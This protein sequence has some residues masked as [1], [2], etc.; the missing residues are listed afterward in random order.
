MSWSNDDDDDLVVWW[1]RFLVVEDCPSTVGTRGWYRGHWDREEPGKVILAVR[2]ANRNFGNVAF[3]LLYLVFICWHGVYYILCL[4]CMVGLTVLRL[5][6]RSWV[7]VRGQHTCNRKCRNI[8]RSW[9]QKILFVVRRLERSMRA[10][11]TGANL[12]EILAT[13]SM[14]SYYF[15]RYF[16]PIMWMIRG[17]F[18]ASNPQQECPHNFSF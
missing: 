18:H 2:V 5:R 1:F 11:M 17:H 12:L 9:C 6:L 4:Y 8:G 13:S 7:N 15:R 3:V 16:S 14:E 10:M